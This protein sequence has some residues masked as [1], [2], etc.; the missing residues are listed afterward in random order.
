MAVCTR[1]EVM[2]IT[3]FMAP[4]PKRDTSEYAGKY[5]HLGFDWRQYGVESEEF[6]NALVSVLQGFDQKEREDFHAQI[7]WRILHGD[8]VDLVQFLDTAFG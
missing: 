1:N 7:I 3:H 8:D 5:R 2:E 6:I 4:Y